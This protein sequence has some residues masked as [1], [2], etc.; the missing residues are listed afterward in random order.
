[1][2]RLIACALLAAAA[3]TPTP[4]EAARQPL[5]AV[6]DPVPNVVLIVVDD[7]T[8]EDIESMPNVQRLLI[9]RGTTFANAYSPFPVCCPARATI[10]TG[11]YPHNHGVLDNAAPLGGFPAFD[12]SRTLATYLTDDYATGIFG[13][14]LNGDETQ[15]T[16]V[17]PGWDTY[18]VPVSGS[19]YRYVDPTMSLNGTVQTMSGESSEIYGRQA[20][21]FIGAH[22]DEPFFVYLPWVAPH[23]GS[24]LGEGGLD[25]HG[26][27]VAPEFRGTYPRIL[28]DDASVDEVD[29]SDKPAEIA[30]LPRLDEETLAGIRDRL[31]QR[32]EALMTVDREVG[33]LFDKV[34]AEGDVA[35]TVFIFASDNGMIQGQHRIA[36]TK[37]RTYEPAAH[38]PLIIR[39]PGFAAGA[40]FDPVVGLQDITPTIL[41][42]TG[43]RFDQPTDLIDGVNL[44]PLA[45]GTLT[46]SRAQ[47]LEIA[48]TAGLSDARA[49]VGALASAKVQR[50]IASLDWYAQ[51]LVTTPGW[52][53]VE[54]P[55]SGEVELYDL[56]ADPF[57]LDNLAADPAYANRVSTMRSRLVGFVSCQGSECR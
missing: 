18:K 32:R 35:D 8:A 57:E 43:Q 55:L 48:E 51:G 38:I 40:T 10:L 31:A 4:G 30:A 52:K 56:D 12:D 36:Q 53:Y 46:S 23:A 24:P 11:Q 3:C 9:D 20:R 54:Y 6:A 33:L 15:G 47:L 25:P 29:V 16:Y 50:R 41:G 17:P 49:D 13:K 2:R 27:W 7:A 5:A 28:P 22:S 14:Y 39:G 37:N 19:T 34:Q 45:A 26:P 42:V 21:A 1:M 44:Q